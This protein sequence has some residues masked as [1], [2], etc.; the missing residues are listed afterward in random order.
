[1]PYYKMS[2][3]PNATYARP[4]V[5]LYATTSG[6][7]TGNPAP[8]FVATGAAAAGGFISQ[9]A[10]ANVI[11]DNGSF[12][13]YVDTTAVPPGGAEVVVLGSDVGGNA[14]RWT[15]GYLNSDVG[16][17][18]GG[19]DLAIKCY[20]DSGAIIATPITIDRETATVNITEGL[21]VNGEVVGAP[22][23][24]GGGVLSIDGT[25]GLS[26][27]YDPLYNPVPPLSNFLASFTSASIQ[28][29]QA[30][31]SANVAMGSFTAPAT[32][33]YL[34]S[35]RLIVNVL[36]G[37]TGGCTVGDPDFL[38]VGLTTSP[39]TVGLAV[40]SAT[41]LRPISMAATDFVVPGE[42]Y[43]VCATNAL[44]LT[45]GVTY[46]MNGQIYNGSATLSFPATG[47]A[48]QL[49]GRIIPLL[50]NT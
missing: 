36:T 44:V 5:P 38:S 9:G 45:A 6:G 20:A 50:A 24:V 25:L 30:S 19:A 11:L 15:V 29:A 23:V 16:D 17:G 12:V 14:P 7:G 32:G 41:F 26:R 40:A 22:A 4:G 31:G 21:V 10:G 28:G 33:L 18:F 48:A 8:Q 3:L 1:M 46:T 47:T 13:S 27:V 43:I 35:A 49:N 37:P 39:P 2:L 34:L 42:D